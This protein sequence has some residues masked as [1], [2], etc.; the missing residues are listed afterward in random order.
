MAAADIDDSIKQKRFRVS[1]NKGTSF[2]KKVKL[3]KSFVLSILLNR[4]ER[5]T[6]KADLDRRIQ[7]FENKCY[8][9]MLGVSY[10]EHTTNE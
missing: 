10:R 9:R 4:C 7:A 2:L 5:G 8:R 3:Y 1:L 6:L